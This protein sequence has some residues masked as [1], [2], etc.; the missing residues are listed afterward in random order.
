MDQVLRTTETQEMLLQYQS[1]FDYLSYYIQRNI[2]K[3]SDVALLYASLETMVKK[4]NQ[5]KNKK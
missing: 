1:L 5:S 2:D 3:P 4:Q